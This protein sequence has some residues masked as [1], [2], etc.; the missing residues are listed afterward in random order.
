MTIPDFAREIRRRSIEMVTAAGTSHIGGCLSMADILAV[1]Y[2]GGIVRHRP[3]D[4]RWEDRD[5][6]ILSKGHCCAAL[7]ATL[8]L[9][10]SFPI[11]ELATFARDGSRLM[12]HAS[13]GVPGVELSTGSLGHGLSVA[14]G[15]ALAARLRGASWRAFAILS[16]GELDEGST[17]EAIHF[18]GHHRLDNLVL[19]VDL[20]GI[21]SLG[22]TEEI[23]ALDPL[24]DK[25]RSF[26]WSVR[27]VDGHDTAALAECLSAVPWVTGMPSCV[28][29]RTVKG[30]GVGFMEDELAWHYRSPDAGLAARAIADL[31]T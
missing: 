4:P 31:G 3:E 25:F 12:A 1:L 17:W 28:L 2:G 14:A 26:R 10:G 9:R 30:K 23:L 6:V 13:A 5:R 20:N 19:V 29:A 8:A 21:Q 7:Y 22:R 15:R 27:E 11:E 24:G 16:D 18:A